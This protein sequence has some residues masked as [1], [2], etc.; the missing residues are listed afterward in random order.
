VE[1]VGALLLSERSRGMLRPSRRRYRLLRVEDVVRIRGEVV[2]RMIEEARHDPSMECCG[3]LG[4]RDAVISAI[5]PAPNALA[6]PTAFEIAPEVLFRFFRHMHSSAVD[7]MGIY[8]SHP[9]GD[10]APSPRDVECAHYPGVAY[11]ILSPRPDAPRPIRAFS[12]RDGRIAELTIEL[13]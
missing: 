7:H 1:D 12:I 11:F 10:N 13:V 2:T 9:T 8:H 6:S 5:F 4:G 3:L